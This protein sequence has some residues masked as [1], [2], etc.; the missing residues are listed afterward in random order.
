MRPELLRPDLPEKIMAPEKIIAIDWSG[1]IDPAGQRRSI[2]AASWTKDGVTL[3]ANR[4]REELASWLIDESKKTPQMVVGVDF[5][6]SYPAWF[7]REN[8]FGN[9]IEFWDLV[10][11]SLGA[12]WLGNHCTDERFWGR[13]KKKPDQFRGA[14]NEKMFRQA[15]LACKVRSHIL[16]QLD[17]DKVKGIAPKS[18]FQIGGAGAVGT[19][20]LRG[21]PILHHLH[22]NGFHVWPFE[23]LSFPL[24]V[25]IYPRLLTGEVKKKQQQAR[26]QYL[27]DKRKHDPMFRK[28]PRAVMRKAETSE[29][30]FDALVSMVEMVR[31]AESFLS[32]SKTTDPITRLEGS[33][34]G[35]GGLKP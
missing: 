34:W 26:E 23:E 18:P 15:D 30:A 13:P 24:I 9:V 1:R 29:D 2:W 31:H 16:N 11:K 8:G 7:V 32:L 33:V 4:T 19:G 3:E 35:A 25:E 28:L 5:C 10:T 22:N 21:I 27:A 6:F 12:Y 14:G 20:T 17:R